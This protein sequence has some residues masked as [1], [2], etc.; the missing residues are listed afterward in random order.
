MFN[1]ERDDGSEEYETFDIALERFPELSPE[2]PL[3]KVVV[4]EPYDAVEGSKLIAVLGL[5]ESGD[6]D[7]IS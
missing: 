1:P 2:P 6:V 3:S 5:A 7:K 4:C